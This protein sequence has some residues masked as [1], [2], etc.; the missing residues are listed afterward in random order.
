[1]LMISVFVTGA[2]KD[3]LER[4]PVDT[5]SSE[6]FFKTKKDALD[7]VTAVYAA[8]STENDQGLY[9]RAIMELELLSDN[10]WSA[11]NDEIGYFNFTADFGTIGDYYNDLYRG[12]N[13]ANL[14]INGIVSIEEIEPALKNRLIGE[15][16]FLRGYYYFLLTLLY[17]DVPIV[18]ESTT[19]PG[20]FVVAKSSAE[21]VYQQV[22]NDLSA[23][24][25]VLP[26][27][28]QYPESDYGRVS[29]GTAKGMLAK[30][31]LFGA[32]ELGNTE[33]YNLAKQKAQE[34]IS[35]NEYQLI[36][37][38][39]PL[40]DYK[41]LFTIENERNAEILFSANHQASSNAFG[42]PNS[43]K[44]IIATLPRQ[45]RQTVW[46]WGKAYVYKE[47]G[48]PSYWEDGDVRRVVNI[49][50][51]GDSMEPTAPNAVFDMS[52]Q[53]RS[54]VRPNHYALR[55][56]AWALPAGLTFTPSSEYNIPIL[57]YADLLLIHA[58][59]S[60]KSSGIDNLTLTSYNAVRK[61]AG[62]EAVN[63]FTVADVLLQRQ[64]ELFGEFH[65]WFD[66]MRTKSAGQ[67][68]SKIVSVGDKAAFSSAKHYKLPLPQRAL[69]LNIKLEQ[70]PNW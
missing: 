7:A 17:G 30:V 2:C 33:W 68:F 1:M 18:L 6:S 31:Y 49:W 63:S 45:T 66:L 52:K 10:C 29:A 39:N 54:M 70:N 13:R 67:A 37:T 14:A 44:V 32:D 60:L 53:N 16:Q 69:D 21:E 46:G 48:E 24:E 35:S 58:E 42:L 15:A 38:D 61:R 41:S 56:Y 40:E 43:T 8:L 26:P 3:F 51:T 57:R 55:K 65:R 9:H 28:S 50:G 59:A 62:L 64:Y 4:I 12:I 36:D 34:V 23:A 25:E 20:G 5:E 47:V 22:I 11:D 27:N 19:D